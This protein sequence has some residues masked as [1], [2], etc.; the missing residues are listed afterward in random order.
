MTLQAAPPAPDPRPRVWPVF[1]GFG[2]AIVIAQILGA[3]T[4][5]VLFIG[6]QI[7][8]GVDL[9]DRSQ[10]L[11]GLP[12]FVVSPPSVIAAAAVSALTLIGASLVAARLGKMPV[13]VR[14]RLGPSRLGWGRFAVAA[15]GALALSKACSAV[16]LLAGLGGSG[17]LNTLNKAFARPS[18]AFLALILLFVG[19]AAP[20]GEEMFFRGFM[21]TRLSQR[22]SRPAAIG[23][24]AAAFGL[25]HLDPV[26]GSFALLLGVYLGW[27]VEISDSIRPAIFAH[28]VNNSLS[29]IGAGAAADVAVAAAGDAASRTLMIGVLAG[30]VVVLG[31]AVLALRSFRPREQPSLRAAAP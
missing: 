24:A 26:Q 14:L 18:P 8:A 29:V 17:M 23:V 10:I 1:V 15:L 27:V 3:L 5:A 2:V 19:A 7:V 25:L 4:L 21:Q 31:I 30:S 6:H 12:Q 20:A 11:E 9:H 13:A 28:A 16:I 22:W